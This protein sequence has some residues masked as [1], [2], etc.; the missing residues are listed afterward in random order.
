MHNDQKALR[1][2]KAAL[3][4]RN[5]Q[6][7][8][9]EIKWRHALQQLRLAE[10]SLQTE[11]ARYHRI[12]TQHQQFIERGVVLD[13]AMQEQR[14]LALAVTRSAVATQQR[15]V[16]VARQLFQEAKAALVQAKV[17]DDVT[18][19]ALQRVVAEVAHQVHAKE[20]ID[21][22]DAQYRQGGSLGI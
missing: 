11:T 21:I 17:A 2:F 7:E 5:L 15:A 18:N 9:A 14:L 10:Q 4:L 16:D 6:R 8:K 1:Q 22:F 3:R 20:L 13:P 12:L 19:K